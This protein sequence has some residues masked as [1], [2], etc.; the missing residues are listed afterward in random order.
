MGE[1]TV[2]WGSDFLILTVSGP[3]HRVNRKQFGH[4]PQRP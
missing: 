2:M 1:E 4:L 3:I